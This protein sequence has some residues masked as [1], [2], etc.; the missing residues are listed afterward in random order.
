MGRAKLISSHE[1]TMSCPLNRN[2]F[3]GSG[4]CKP[5]AP[6]SAAGKEIE[7]RMLEAQ[8]ARSAQDSKYF[9]QVA[10]V[11]C[12]GG[13]CPKPGATGLA[14]CPGGVCPKPAAVAPK[15]K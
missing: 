9:P 11:P 5:E 13:V 10:G 12:A 1:E 3:A 7:A 2:R 14:A 6:V 8:K 15:K 4:Y